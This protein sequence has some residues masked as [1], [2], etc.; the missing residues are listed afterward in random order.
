MFFIV[1]K[2][3]SANH[4][5]KSGLLVNASAQLEIHIRAFCFFIL[6]TTVANIW[7]QILTVTMFAKPRT[8]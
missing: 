8:C 4:Y 5:Q 2:S 7:K 3:T 6:S 1:S